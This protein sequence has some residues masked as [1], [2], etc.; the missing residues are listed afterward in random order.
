MSG[1]ALQ[2]KPRSLTH[3]A[4]AVAAFET[5]G[6]DFD[7]SARVLM[8]RNFTVEG[9]LPFLKL[10]LFESGIEPRVVLGDYDV[11]HQVALDPGSIL[12]EEPFDVVVLALVLETFSPSYRDRDWS[13]ESTWQHLRPMLDDF[14]Q[15]ATGRIVLNS[16]LPLLQWESGLETAVGRRVGELNRALASYVAQHGDRFSLV[17]WGRITRVL[18]EQQ[19]IDRRY[20]YQARAPLRPAFCSLWAGELAR[21]VAAQKRGARKCLVLDCD[22]T[23]WG[24]VV[25][26][27]GLEGIQLDPN[28]Y[29]GNV[30]Y[31]FQVAI[32]RCLDAGVVLALCSKNNEGDV[33]EVI[34][35]HPH[36]LI[37][38]GDIAAW[39]INWRDKASGLRE[40][41]DELRLGLDQLVFVDDQAMECELVSR[42]LPE[43]EVLQVP[44]ALSSLPDLLARHGLFTGD[45]ST[46]ED[47]SR[48][49]LYQQEV[50]RRAA[51]EHHTDLA[52]F[53]RSLELRVR[54]GPASD[55]DIK[56]V[57]QLTQKTNQFNL[58]TR[59][60]S[61]AQIAE[62]MQNRDAAV[63]VMWVSDRFGDAGLTAVLIARRCDGVGSID[64]LLLSCRVL[65]RSLESVF[66]TE[67][68]A[69]LE[70]AWSLDEW[71]AEYLP[72][73]KNQQ[74]ADF[75]DRSGFGVE[76][77]PAVSGDKPVALDT[78]VSSATSGKSTSRKSPSGKSYRMAAGELAP[79][80]IDWVALD[81]IAAVSPT[82][83]GHEAFEEDEKRE[84]GRWS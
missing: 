76:G 50:K 56:R 25:G 13:W 45:A 53:L 12:F 30:Y 51:R 32:R 70:H 33:F 42:A 83:A 11:L 6:G 60:Y 64:S 82:S 1:R 31:E 41:A 34:D 29:P 39:R 57:S 24:G 80:G 48:S 7:Q 18:G 74:V 9:V 22:N 49:A 84:E 44:E 75:W 59:R 20:W 35:R 3:V 79:T 67:C 14:A 2:T 40:L 52:D 38:R 72:T 26:E 43:V 65:G 36:C 23:L 47:R 5:S 61:E 19:S 77:E 71:R 58:T 15:R 78:S 81:W 73:A 37:G 28:E 27:D 21:L 63:L 10:E 55:V 8:L 54:V 68:L 62:L 4:R 46:L 66:L 17:D 16:F 69:R